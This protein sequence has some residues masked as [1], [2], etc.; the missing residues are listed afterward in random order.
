MQKFVYFEL[1]SGHKFLI[2]FDASA[3]T[4]L[5]LA[6]VLSD[7]MQHPT[8]GFRVRHANMVL[9]MHHSAGM[10]F[11]EI[12]QSREVSE[13]QGI[14]DLRRLERATVKTVRRWIKETE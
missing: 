13:V 11:R 6:E 5:E 1:N 4:G 14:E 7:W 3:E 10:T 8:W 9:D 12:M 2:R